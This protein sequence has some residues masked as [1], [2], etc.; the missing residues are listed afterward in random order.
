MTSH[1]VPGGI[2]AMPL[3]RY[4]RR[5]W[6]M[7]P[8]WIIREALKKKDVRVNGARCGAEAIVKGG[9]ALSLYIDARWLEPAPEILF[10]DGRL[11]VAVKPQGLPVDVDRDGV[12][13]DTL[14]TRL[15]R[16]WPGARLCHRLDA[17]TGGI[18]LAAADEA[19]LEQALDAFRDH[20]GVGKA[21]RALAVGTFDRPEG[22]LDAFLLKDA[23]RA[24]VKIL[25]NSAPGAKPIRTRYRVI[26]ARGNGLTE[27]A[28]E[29]VTGRTHQLR[30]HMAD[31]GH[32]L[33]G[34][35]RYGDRAANRRYQCARLCL[36]HERLTVSDDS[37]LVDYRGMIFEAR[38]PEWGKF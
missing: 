5:A 4:L 25:H 20:R 27:V 6:P 3:E 15:E 37:P 29:P 21:Y 17:A 1:T 22:T 7:L 35:D 11:I 14:L 32:P 28:L 10:S 36:W 24:E 8:G 30:A 2:P 31:F 26:G 13:A 12:G 18:V 33:L 38:T 23:R 34:D 9:D 19:V 16:R